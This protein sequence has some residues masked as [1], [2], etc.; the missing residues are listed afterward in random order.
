MNLKALQSN[1]FK[2]DKGWR[3]TPTFIYGIGGIIGF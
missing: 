1:A 3:G 2:L